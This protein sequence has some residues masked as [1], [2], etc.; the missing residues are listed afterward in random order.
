MKYSALPIRLLTLL[1]IASIGL[2]HGAGLNMD[3]AQSIVYTSTPQPLSG[4]VNNS[5][6]AHYYRLA[7]KAG[8]FLSAILSPT[9][10]DLD[11][12]L[13][14]DTNRSGSVDTVEVIRSSTAG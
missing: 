6:P 5:Q 3:S 10:Q 13:I 11:L 9:S 4:T 1:C 2:A 7:V 8:T 12:D 14:E